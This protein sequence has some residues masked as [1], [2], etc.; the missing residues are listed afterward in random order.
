[1]PAGSFEISCAQSEQVESGVESGLAPVLVLRAEFA[2]DVIGGNKLIMPG[3]VYI[4]TQFGIEE[5][6]TA[7]SYTSDGR[8][9]V[10]RAVHGLDVLRY[11]RSHV[12]PFLRGQDVSGSGSRVRQSWCTITRGAIPGDGADRAQSLADET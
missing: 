7:P 10:A 12:G 8:A 9:A 6:R 3:R 2:E 5:R 1:M 11:A 4:G